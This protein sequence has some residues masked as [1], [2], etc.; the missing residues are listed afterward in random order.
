MGSLPSGFRV[1][2]LMLVRVKSSLCDHGTVFLSEA[3][4]LPPPVMVM[5]KHCHCG[6]LHG[7]SLVIAPVLA[8]THSLSLDPVNPDWFNYSGTGS[9]G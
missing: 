1:L 6:E 5:L 8:C 7:W 9:P 4:M 2:P 3:G